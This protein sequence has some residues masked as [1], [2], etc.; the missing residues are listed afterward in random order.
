MRDV[1]IIASCVILLE[2]LI[3]TAKIKE[4]LDEGTL[5]HAV[6]RA[7]LSIVPVVPWEGAPVARGP[8]ADQLPK[9]I[10][11]CFDV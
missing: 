10:P 6:L 5:R 1:I 4:I 8:S 9:F 11:R 7:G 2:K 3:I